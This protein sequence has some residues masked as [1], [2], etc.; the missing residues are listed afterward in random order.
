[1]EYHV[2]Y[3]RCGASRSGGWGWVGSTGCLFPVDPP[4]PPLPITDPLAPPHTMHGRCTGGTD[5]PGTAPCTGTLS[6]HLLRET[7]SEALRGPLQPHLPIWVGQYTPPP[8][9][10]LPRRSQARPSRALICASMSSAVL[11]VVS[12]V[13]TRSTNMPRC[14]PD[15]LEVPGSDRWGISSTVPSA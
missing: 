8:F 9:F 4:A 5:R 7:L 14:L 11:S 13:S 3:F 15:Q 2:R 1:V 10:P 6:D 12:L